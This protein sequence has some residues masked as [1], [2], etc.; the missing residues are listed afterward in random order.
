MSQ[1]IL[2][3]GHFVSLRTTAFGFRDS[4]ITLRS[5]DG[6]GSRLPFKFEAVSL[7]FDNAYQE[8][9][10]G[11]TEDATHDTANNCADLGAR[12]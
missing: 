8:G 10:Q 9:Y 2:R 11:Y 7:T 3:I 6:L 12:S 1:S 4:T 5:C